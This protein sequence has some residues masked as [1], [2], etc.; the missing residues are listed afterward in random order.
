MPDV[1]ART[2][3]GPKGDS[4]RFGARGVRRR[5]QPHPERH[6]GEGRLAEISNYLCWSSHMST[7]RSTAKI[8]DGGERRRSE[9]EWGACFGMAEAC[10]GNSIPARPGT[11]VGAVCS[12][13]HL[14]TEGWALR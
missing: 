14:T 10:P 4:K 5:P 2:A 8:A 12:P 3:A 7:L 13:R 1:V 9:F 6:S 11:A